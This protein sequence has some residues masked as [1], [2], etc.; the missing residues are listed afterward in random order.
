MPRLA[1][2]L[3][4]RR[5]ERSALFGQLI[6]DA[7]VLFRKQLRFIALYDSPVQEKM[8]VE[9]QVGAVS[10]GWLAL[11]PAC[12]EAEKAAFRRWLRFVAHEL[13]NHLS[14]PQ[15]HEREVI[16]ARIAQAARMIRERHE[17]D[18]SLGDVARAVGLSRER[19]S[20][21]FH[22][23]LGITFSEYLNHA[24]LETAR[25]LLR[26]GNG[27]VTEIALASG[28]Q[29]LSQFHRRFRAAEN[30]SPIAYRDAARRRLVEVKAGAKGYYG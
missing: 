9:L 29:S 1:E 19:L 14:E 27:T 3:L 2:Q 20:R 11:S 7:N 25:R 21:L 23:T 28:F 12:E 22:E 8:T 16:P 15:G 13:A 26:E 5:L 30:T 6:G 4:Q 17:E 24:R 10:I 18:L